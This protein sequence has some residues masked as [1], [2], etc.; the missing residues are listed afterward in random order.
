MTS[1]FCFPRRRQ[2]YLKSWLCSAAAAH[3]LQQLQQQPMQQQKQKLLP[4]LLL[5]QL[6]SRW[7]NL[8]ETWA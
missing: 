1:A 6:S 8:G 5:G 7:T 3:P 4:W 2:Q